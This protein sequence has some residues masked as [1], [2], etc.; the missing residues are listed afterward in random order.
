MPSLP[1]QYDLN[2]KTLKS[3][4]HSIPFISIDIYDVRI[5]PN[6]VAESKKVKGTFW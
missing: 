4:I 6:K 5:F 1:K 2:L 3:V